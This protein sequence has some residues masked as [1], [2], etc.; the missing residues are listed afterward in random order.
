M[1]P[2]VE[3]AGAVVDT[4]VLSYLLRGDSRAG[5]FE[6]FLV[7]QLLSAS[8]MTIAELD[9]WALQRH[10]GPA[11]LEQLARFLEPFVIV[12]ADRALCRAW[13]AVMDGAR[14]R[15]RPMGTT[16]AWIAAT[17]LRLDVPLVTNNQADDAGVADLRLLPTAP[18]P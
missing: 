4:D 16:D 12:L 9:R 1:A 8:C 10:W 11:R 7:G 18:A 17:A 5:Q 3:S 6:P 14:R 2:A 13:A 15:G